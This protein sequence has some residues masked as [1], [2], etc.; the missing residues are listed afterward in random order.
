M[1][2]KQYTFMIG[3]HKLMKPWEK[4]SLFAIFFL[5]YFVFWSYSFM[6]GSQWIID[7]SIALF[8]LILLILFSNVLKLKKTG[9]ILLNLALLTHNLGTFGYYSLTW[10]FLAYD[11]LVH[12]ISLIVIAYITFNI[13]SIRFYKVPNNRDIFEENKYL[14]IIL[15][16][17]A[18]ISLSVL[19][20][21]VE[22]GGYYYL[23]EG[24][25][26]LLAGVGDSDPMNNGIRDQYGDT[27]S[28][29]IVNIFGAFIG[30]FGYYYFRIRNP[31]LTH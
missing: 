23:G 22:F 3:K 31:Y 29:L 11:N 28:D 17:C 8:T 15:V 2:K 18:A 30:A 13:V 7:N 10:K 5:I 25:G 4:W 26:L 1:L 20:E 12:F 19:L 16:M 14:F 27:M 24:E 9:F 21:L 6:T